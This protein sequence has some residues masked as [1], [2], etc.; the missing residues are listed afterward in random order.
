MASKLLVNIRE[1]VTCPICLELL[2][3]PLSLDCGH[4]FCQA[5]ITANNKESVA[6]Q[7]EH[8]SCPVCRISYEPGHLRLNRQLANI[9][10]QLR[11]VKLSPEEEQ[12]R[13]LCERHGEKLLLFC[14]QDGK[15]IC[16]LCERSQE[17]RGH[18]TFLIEE[19]AQE[20]QGKLQGTL[21]QM[22]KKLQQVG[23]LE[24]ELKER[25]TYWESDIQSEKQG[26]KA[27]FAELRDLLD[28][29]EQK[30]LQKLTHE[31]EDILS[32]LAEDEDN[33]IQQSQ[34]IEV[35]ISDMEHRLQ[36]SVTEKLQDVNDILQRSCTLTLKEPKV[37]PQR[38][39][40]VFLPPDLK[41]ML[42]RLNVDVTL[43]QIISNSNVE[44]SANGRK[45]RVLC[46]NYPM[47]EHPDASYEDYSVMGSPVF[48]NG[49]HYWEV[50]V[51]K[52]IAWILGVCGESH[53]LKNN[54]VLVPDLPIF[55]KKNKMSNPIFSFYSRF[56]PGFHM[57]VIRL[58]SQSV[59]TAFDDTCCHDPKIL[60]L[61]MTVPP[62]RVGV[63]L[64]YE[65]GTV[66]FYNITNHGSLIYE[67][68][69][70]AFPKRILPYFNLMNC[71]VPMTICK[72]NS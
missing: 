16:W 39:R 70:C 33:L 10:E 64:D 27:E 31:E 42:Q 60:T 14:K 29:A 11:G 3:E 46:N 38:E 40:R 43:N 13:D 5:C 17:H 71:K 32:K 24:A 12:K 62:T 68:S 36:V 7:D 35:L 26:V 28:I 41:G 65:A 50:D 69:K 51:S 44:I 6:N 52:K 37:L 72:P 53:C 45:M 8:S 55:G 20:Y 22:R 48:M 54:N 2:T 1:E 21:K 25:R 57:W 18:P 63:F 66:S 34:L 30:A 67:Y 58:H 23:Q 4:S 61:S 59:Y 19:I 49:K 9:A 15:V 47:K 56:Q